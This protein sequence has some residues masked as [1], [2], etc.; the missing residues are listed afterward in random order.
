MSISVITKFATIESGKQAAINNTHTCAG[1][2]P[3]VTD[4]YYSHD[5][6]T[7]DA[8]LLKLSTLW[9]LGY[10]KERAKILANCNKLN[11]VY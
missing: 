4:L 3:F 11:P 10:N 9:D 8:L 5:E 2:D 1:T 7:R 6:G